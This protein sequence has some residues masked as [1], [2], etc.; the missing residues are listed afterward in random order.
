MGLLAFH[1]LLLLTVLVFRKKFRVQSVAFFAIGALRRLRLRR[2]R[3]CSQ[4]AYRELRSK[5]QPHPTP[6]AAALQ[7]P[8]CSTRS[9]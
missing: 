9:G 7:W 8:W 1:A 6:C 2:G 3:R 4:P 5:L